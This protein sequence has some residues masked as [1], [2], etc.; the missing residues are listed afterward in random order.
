MKRYSAL[1]LGCWLMICQGMADHADKI[2]ASSAVK[3]GL[4]VLLGVEDP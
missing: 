4:V 3:G 1:W 2:L